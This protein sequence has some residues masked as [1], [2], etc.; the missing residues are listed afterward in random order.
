L[1]GHRKRDSKALFMIQQA[2]DDEIFP[3]ISASE[4]SKQAWEILKQEYFGGDK[5]ITVKLQTLRHDFEI[6][7]MNENKSVQGYLSRTSAITNRKRSYVR[8][9]IIRLLC[10]KC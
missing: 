9:L 7:F 5:V 3:H 1:R 2:L 8:K 6:L 4:T 10:L